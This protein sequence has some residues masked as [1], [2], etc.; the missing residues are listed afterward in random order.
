MWRATS[1]RAHSQFAW[2]SSVPPGDALSRSKMSGFY[3]GERPPAPDRLRPAEPTQHCRVHPWMGCASWR[4][5]RAS[6]RAIG[7]HPAGPAAFAHAHGVIAARCAQGAAFARHARRADCV[8]RRT[9]SRISPRAA[10]REPRSNAIA[11]R[12]R[13][14]RRSRS[15]IMTSLMTGMILRTYGGCHQGQERQS[16][17][18]RNRNSAAAYHVGSARGQFGVYA[19]DTVHEHLWLVGF[20][21][22]LRAISQTAHRAHVGDQHQSG[23]LKIRLAEA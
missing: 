2:K 3:C 11:V 1:Y 15:S 22:D 18:C 8:A 10:T 20:A 23:V 19:I 12:H 5:R 14:G 17:A 6:C 9:P 4:C 21:L 16:P 13:A 7:A